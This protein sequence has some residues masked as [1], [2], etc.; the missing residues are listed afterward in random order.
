[1]LLVECY[2][3]DMTAPSF[4]GHQHPTWYRKII[5][6]DHAS[7]LELHATGHFH[8]LY[9]ANEYILFFYFIWCT[10]FKEIGTA[11]ILIIVM[12]CM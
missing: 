6:M 10:L 1:M 4:M 2:F 11:M 3:G 7:P 12:L 5:L 8:T 9:V